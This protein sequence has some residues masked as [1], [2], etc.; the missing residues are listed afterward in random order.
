MNPTM[1][2]KGLGSG[3]KSK[4][5]SLGKS[6]KLPTML[7]HVGRDSGNNTDNKLLN[8]RHAYLQV[9]QEKMMLSPEQS[10]VQR[11]QSKTDKRRSRPAKFELVLP[12]FTLDTYKFSTALPLPHVAGHWGVASLIT[13]IKSKDLLLILKLLL[14]ERSVLV[15]GESSHL[16]SSCAC[17]L[18]E[19]LKPY[20]WASNFMPLLPCGMLDFV[21]SPVP[22]LIGMTVK[23]H[24]HGKEIENDER[25]VEAMRTGLSVVNL[26][27]NAVRL[28]TE[29]EIVEIIQGC[30]T[31]K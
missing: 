25:V 1:P 5:D 31:P 4:R 14:V 20:D 27:S 8:F 22:F 10:R 24:K 3:V 19:L 12:T 16:V 15:I 23:N 6:M 26:S 18:L 29:T 7:R 9:L 21:N 30:P 28:T 11:P 17:A 2:V 13:R